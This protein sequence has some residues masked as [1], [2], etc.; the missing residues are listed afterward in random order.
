[1]KTTFHQVCI[2]NVRVTH[3]GSLSLSFLRKPRTF[4]VRFFSPVADEGKGRDGKISVLLFSFKL[5]FFG[6]SSVVKSRLDGKLP[7]V[8]AVSN[9]QSEARHRFSSSRLVNR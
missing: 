7:S 3:A 1:M 5:A 6:G 4:L 9:T 8:F 2:F